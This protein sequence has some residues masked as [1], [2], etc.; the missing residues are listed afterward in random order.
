MIR[1]K[2][3]EKFKNRKRVLRDIDYG[4][5]GISEITN[6]IDPKHKEINSPLRKLKLVMEKIRNRMGLTEEIKY[7][8]SGSWGMAF[9]IGDKVIKLTSNREEVSVA[10]K[11]VGKEIPNVVN[12]YQ[13]LYIEEYGIWAI[14]MDLV[15]MLSKK[16]KFLIDIF[17]FCLDLEEVMDEIRPTRITKSEA[18]SMWIE[19]QDL[20]ES[21]EKSG[22]PTA[23]MHPDNIGRFHGKLVHFDIMPE[24]GQLEISKLSN[25]KN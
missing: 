12:Y 10:K 14:L 8:N 15:N 25:V 18:L 17:Q 16:E 6:K 4:K 19:Y 2:L 22:I 9:K 11:L 20:V 23:D 7:I 21:L 1:I 24:S 13:I 3:F 5:E